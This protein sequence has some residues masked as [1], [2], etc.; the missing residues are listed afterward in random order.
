MYVRY[1]P[2]RGFTHPLVKLVNGITMYKRYGFNIS[3]KYSSR[4][5]ELTAPNGINFVK[6]IGNPNSRLERVRSYILK[7][8]PSTKRAILRDVFGKEIG[9]NGVTYGWGA[10][11]FGYGVRHGLFTKTR[12]GNTVLWGVTTV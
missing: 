2:R 11:L 1:N 9:P 10:Y 6:S 5:A 3:P 4:P 12:K 8:G 7:N